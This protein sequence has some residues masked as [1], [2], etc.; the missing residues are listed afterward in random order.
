MVTTGWTGEEPEETHP[1]GFAGFAGFIA[2]MRGDPED[3]PSALARAL[4]AP[5][6]PDPVY[7][8]DDR[9]AALLTRGYR[10][11]LIQE[12]AGRLG[13]CQAELQAEVEKIGKGKRRAEHVRRAF[14]A[15]Q[16]R[17]LDIQAALGDEGDPD[18]VAFLERRA[19]SLQRQM[20]DATDAMSPPERRT[21]DPLEAAA[22][23]AH[24]AFA[25]VT[26]ARMAGAQTRRPEPRPFGSASRGAG[27]STEH[28]GPH[29]WVCAEGRRMEAGDT[30]AHAP[31]EVITT[32]YAYR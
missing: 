23:R 24:A 4:A 28:T 6:R 32:G 2:A 1:A 21:P 10:P 20:T 18:R 26:R 9:Q 22:S 16:V 12:L 3:R 13:D 17:A 25:E 30:A 27:R 7:D 8:D 15:G 14:E 5:D 29:C 19:A 31:G 11:G